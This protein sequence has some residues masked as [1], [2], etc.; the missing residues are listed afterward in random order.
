MTNWFKKLGIPKNEITDFLLQ[1]KI[2]DAISQTHI[3]HLNDI[4]ILVVEGLCK[5]DDYYDVKKIFCTPFCIHEH[6]E[7]PIVQDESGF[8]KYLSDIERDSWVSRIKSKDFS[9][10]PKA[11]YDLFRSKCSDED[12]TKYVKELEDEYRKCVKEEVALLEEKANEIKTGFDKEIIA[13]KRI[14]NAG[15]KK[16]QYGSK[17]AG[18]GSSDKYIS[19]PNNPHDIKARDEAQYND[20]FENE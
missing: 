11:Y 12:K 6:I 1:Q 17:I 8:K 2:L 18:K 13:R 7:H 3:K 4:D 9:S 5:Y 19:N 14:L 10:T 20:D 16:G 15:M